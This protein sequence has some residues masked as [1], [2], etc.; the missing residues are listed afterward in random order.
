MITSAPYNLSAIVRGDLRQITLSILSAFLLIGSFPKFGIGLTAWV[1]LIPLLIALHTTEKPFRA[2]LFGFITGMIFHI[3]LLYWVAQVI[4]MYGYLP[5]YIGISAMLLLCLYLSIY[6]SLFAA[7]VVFLRNRGFSEIVSAPLLWTGLEFL[8]SHLFTG[9]PWENLAYSQYKYLHLI[10][11]SDVTGIYGVSFLIVFVNVVLFDLI[12]HRESAKKALPE[13]ASGCIILALLFG[14]GQFSLNRIQSELKRAEAMEVSLIQGNIDQNIKWNPLF[15]QESIDIYQNMSL[16]KAP[17]GRGL[18]VWPETA[19]PFFFQEES[20]LS[21]V[22]RNIPKLTSD[23]L[24]FGSPSY[25]A[26]GAKTEY[27][28]SAF[29]LSPNGSTAGK[30]DKTHLVPYGEY[31]PL[32]H[33]FPFIN[34]LVAGIGDFRKGDGV[35][36]IGIGRHDLGILICYE[37]IFPEISRKYK[38]DG[39]NLLVNITNDAWFGKTSAPYQHLSMTV[40]R[41]VENRTFLVRAAN[42]GISAII[43]PS[44]KVMKQT[45]LFERTVV[46]GSVK[47]LDRKTIYALYGD[48]FIYI[49]LILLGVIFFSSIKGELKQCLKNLRIK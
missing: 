15:Q 9:F 14:Y 34:K 6:F 4:V 23:W 5:L 35:N 36:P 13:L 32:R 17:V 11:F 7:G 43:D 29:L 21:S 12:V 10:Q 26:G 46:R 8:K 2:L 38:A 48:I 44:G 22:V 40:F 31:V 39:T 42:T 37:A 30:Y 33:F 45:G 19:T 3:G 18:I 16:K 47:F 28:N 25:F 41:A 24:L 20:H 1:A 49:C 27:M